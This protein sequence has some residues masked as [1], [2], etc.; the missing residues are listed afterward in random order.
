MKTR[1]VKLSEVVALLTSLGYA[2]EFNLSDLEDRPRNPVSRRLWLQLGVAGFA[3]GN[4]MLLSISSYLGLDAFSGPGLRKLFGWISLALAL[5]ALVYSGAD[6]WRAAWLAL[7]QRVLTIDVPIAVGIAA[8]AAWSTAEV[9]AGRGP[10]YF[11]SLTGLLFFLLCGKLFQQKTYDRLAF[12]RDYKSFFPLVHPAP[13][14]GERG[15]HLAFAV[16]GRRP[17]WSFATAN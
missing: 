16:A 14:R 4:I 13:E 3:F 12:D 11:D 1:R 5:P 7:R 10:G 9:F 2:P 6:Y 17:A 8:L 15:A